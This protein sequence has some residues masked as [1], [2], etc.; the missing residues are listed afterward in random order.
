MTLEPAAD[1]VRGEGAQELA[2]LGLA[3]GRDLVVGDVAAGHLEVGGNGRDHLPGV[4]QRGA[5]AVDELR[6]GDLAAF[7]LLEQGGD[8][9]RDIRDLRARDNQTPTTPH[10]HDGTRQSADPG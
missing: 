3:R 7:G 5:H 4:G 10:D 6:V 1:R 8:T 2:A 9:S